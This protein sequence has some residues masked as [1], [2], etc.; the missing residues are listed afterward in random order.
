M[1]RCLAHLVCREN[2][3]GSETVLES[4]YD[5]SSRRRSGRPVQG[6]QWHLSR[7]YAD[8]REAFVSQS[9]RNA[10]RENGNTNAA[11]AC[12]LFRASEKF[13]LSNA[14]LSHNRRNTSL[15]LR[16]LASVGSHSPRRILRRL[17]ECV[18]SNP[19]FTGS[20][21]RIDGGRPA[22]RHSCHRPYA[23]RRDLLLW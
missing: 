12:N 16:Q 19:A 1:D 10:K 14:G 22:N 17:S 15:R 9:S 13:Q 2:G 5:P 21:L 18:R 11:A 20:C 6:S 23:R 4:V 3:D 8:R 7:E